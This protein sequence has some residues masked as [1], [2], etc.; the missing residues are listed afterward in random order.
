MVDSVKQYNLAGVASEVELGKKGA[1]IDGTSSDQVKL[2]NNAGN[3]INA[4]IADGTEDS[5]AVTKSQLDDASQSKLSDV[6]FVVSYDD[7]TVDLGTF[8]A[9]TTVLSVTVEKGAG[10]WVGASA[11]T[12]ITVGT[13]GNAD[14][15]F[16]GFDTDVQSVDETN[17]L[18]ESDALVKAVVT[19]GDATSGTAKIRIIYAGVFTAAE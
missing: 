19:P 2:K 1:K 3:L 4:E 13:A 6:E 18:F 5:H 9:D 16:G 17:H 7:G 12:N 11:A 8:S 15:L 10:N 14:L